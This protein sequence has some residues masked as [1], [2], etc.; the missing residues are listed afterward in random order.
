ML[1][2]VARTKPMVHIAGM[3]LPATAIKE[4]SYDERV[5]LG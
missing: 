4:G 3:E 1:P 5:D 2:P